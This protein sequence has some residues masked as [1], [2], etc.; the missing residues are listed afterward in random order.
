VVRFFGLG[1]FVPL[2]VKAHLKR[3]DDGS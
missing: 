2:W 3:R 1:L